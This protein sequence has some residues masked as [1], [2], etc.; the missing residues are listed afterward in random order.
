MLKV[1]IKL[2]LTRHVYFI[3]LRCH[4]LLFFQ[5]DVTYGCL[6]RER[7]LTSLN[8]R[9]NIN[10]L[11]CITWLATTRTKLLTYL[12]NRLCIGTLTWHMMSAGVAH[13]GSV[14]RYSCSLSYNFCKLHHSTVLFFQFCRATFALGHTLL[15]EIYCNLLMQK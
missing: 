10:V 13:V 11:C 14:L 5:L 4:I 15:K 1:H 9:V 6:P 3:C 8:R 12:R 7:L 2:D